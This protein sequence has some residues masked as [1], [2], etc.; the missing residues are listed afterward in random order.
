MGQGPLKTT[1]SHDGQRY[2]DEPIT[3]KQKSDPVELA[4][5]GAFS[6][7]PP[8]RRVVVTGHQRVRLRWMKPDGK[9]GLVPK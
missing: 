4:V 7:V 3:V 8:R 9:G 6:A 2:V 1:I 5:E